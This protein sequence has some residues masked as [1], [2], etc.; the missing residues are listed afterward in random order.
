M[1]IEET[2]DVELFIEAIR[3]HPEIW[4]TASE[5][6]HDRAKKRNAWVAICEMFCEGFEELADKEK[7][8]IC[9]CSYDV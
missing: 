8:E 4:D 9:K 6:Y 2:L 3:S 7:N 5:E 1:N